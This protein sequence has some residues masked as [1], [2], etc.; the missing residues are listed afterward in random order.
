MEPTKPKNS[1]VQLLWGAALVLMG[2]AVFFRLPQ[3]VPKLAAMGQSDVTIGFIR[4]CFYIIGFIL[5]GGG[6]RKFVSHFKPDE[7][8]SDDTSS[9]NEE[10]K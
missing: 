8:G 6:I 9:D 10:M 4:V 3:V 7:K 2:I 1:N 5:V